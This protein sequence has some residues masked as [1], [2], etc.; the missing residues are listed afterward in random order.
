MTQLSTFTVGHIRSLY[1]SGLYHKSDLMLRFI[2]QLKTPETLIKVLNYGIQEEVRED[3]RMQIFGMSFVFDAADA[4]HKTLR[5]S[6]IL[7]HSLMIEDPKNAPA[8]F[9]QKKKKAEKILNE[10]LNF[11]NKEFSTNFTVYDVQSRLFQD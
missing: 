5:E 4:Y 6:A 3:L 7:E 11:I 1:A 9:E 10:K 8:E 2:T